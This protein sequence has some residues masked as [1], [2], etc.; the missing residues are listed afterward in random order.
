MDKDLD[1]EKMARTLKSRGFH[2]FEIYRETTTRAAVYCHDRTHY[3]NLS[4]AG[5]TA[6]AALKNDVTHHFTTAGPLTGTEESP[7]ESPKKF[8]G[9]LD[10]YRSQLPPGQQTLPVMEYRD[11]VRSYEVLRSDDEIIRHGHDEMASVTLNRAGQRVEWHRRSIEAVLLDLERRPSALATAFQNESIQPVRWPLPEGELPTVFS[12]RAVAKLMKPMIRLCEADH[13]LGRD[14][15]LDA[16][17]ELPSWLSL[18]DVAP[19]ERESFDFQ[20]VVK[21]N[22]VLVEKGRISRLACDRAFAAEIASAP[23]GHARRASYVSPVGI[24]L[25]NVSLAQSGLP[26]PKDGELLAEMGNGIYIGELDL[27]SF[28][29]KKAT[30]RVLLKEGR[31]VH[32]GE[33][34][35]SLEPIAMDVPLSSVLHHCVALGPKPETTGLLMSKASGNHVTEISTSAALSAAVPYPGSVP[36]SHYW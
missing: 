14:Y 34:G 36:R 9:I 32:H 4:R 29:P 19:T 28:S 18:A 6:V 27:L 26:S 13:R 23:T 1:L 22:L 25:W 15:F 35:E 30:C 33:L 7:T 10:F 16:I 21:K 2:H 11:E 12:S 20:G 17:G 8:S 31:L 3:V 5:G 24:G